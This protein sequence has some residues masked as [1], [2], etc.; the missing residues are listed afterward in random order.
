MATKTKADHLAAARASKGR[1][2]S[3]K[4]EGC[5]AWDANQFLRHFH[6][7]MAWYRLE[8][9]GKELK[10]KVINW[11]AA[12]GYTK[13]QIAEFKKLKIIAVAQL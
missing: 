12:N 4:W 13:D 11:M 2:L 7:S 1:D 3:P 6:S 5:D 10:P 8:S 9:S